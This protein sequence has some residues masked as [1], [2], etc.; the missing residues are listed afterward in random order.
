[1]YGMASAVAPGLHHPFEALEAAHARMEN[2]IAMLE[3]LAADVERQGGDSEAS[4]AARIVL[5]FFETAGLQHQRDEEE[6]LFPLLREK[7]A[8][9]GRPEVSAVINE[10]EADHA[11]MDLQWSGIRQCLDALTR[12][13]QS[14]FAPSD[15]AGF[16]W[17][18]RRHMGRETALILPFAKETLDAAEQQALGGRMAT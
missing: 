6:H 15:I 1:M 4:E 18:Q 2:H 7:A 11:A 9:R 13:E 14:V 12:G 10:V 5:R 8:E 3:R 17:L 16:A